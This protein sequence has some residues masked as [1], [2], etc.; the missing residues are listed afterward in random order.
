MATPPA[1]RGLHK[2]EGGTC[3]TM[4]FGTAEVEAGPGTRGGGGRDRR[5]R[6]ALDSIPL[7]RCFTP[8]RWTPLR[9]TPRCGVVIAVGDQE[10]AREMA[11]FF[12]AKP[13]H[14]RRTSGSDG[15]LTP[16]PRFGRRH[17]PTRAPDPRGIGHLVP[18]GQPLHSNHGAALVRTKSAGSRAAS[19]AA[20]AYPAD[21][22]GYN[23]HGTPGHEAP[24]APAD[25][26]VD[27]AELMAGLLEGLSGLDRAVAPPSE[28]ERVALFAD[29]AD[30]H[31]ELDL[32]Q[33]PVCLLFEDPA[34]RLVSLAQRSR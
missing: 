29:Y 8:T 24:P 4:D 23:V 32:G 16:T 19:L 22:L 18:G 11:R 30:V 13:A 9:W 14:R 31:P 12:A 2:A 21:L 6:T 1:N 33:H 28:D 15:V 26:D 7:W 5:R 20:R 17:A 27:D 34:G 3:R 25:V 10:L